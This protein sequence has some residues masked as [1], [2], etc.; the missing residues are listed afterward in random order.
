MKKSSVYFLLAAVLI[1]VAIIVGAIVSDADGNV[2]VIVPLGV[3]A[4]FAVVIAAG[5]VAKKGFEAS[6]EENRLGF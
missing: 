6:N 1:L 4:I 3:I 5:W 2:G